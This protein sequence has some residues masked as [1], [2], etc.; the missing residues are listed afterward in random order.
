MQEKQQRKLFR[1]Y[2]VFLHILTDPNGCIIWESIF[3][4]LPHLF[5]VVAV[6]VEDLLVPTDGKNH[7]TSPLAFAYWI[8]YVLEVH[9]SSW[10]QDS[11][12]RIRFLRKAFFSLRWSAGI[13]FKRLR[14]T[15][16]RF[17]RKAFFSLRRSTG[18]FFSLSSKFSFSTFLTWASVPCSLMASSLAPISLPWG[19]LDGDIRYSFIPWTSCSRALLDSTNLLFCSIN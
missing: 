8:A 5:Q 11:I 9:L 13:V 6:H 7:V 2:N 19:C 10:G 17:L 18:I 4:Y 12:F 1:F 16:I 15:W 14:R 3:S